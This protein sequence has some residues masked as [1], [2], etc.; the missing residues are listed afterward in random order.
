MSGHDDKN[1]Q[2][3]AAP[4]RGDDRRGD[5]ISDN[6]RRVYREVVDEPLPDAFE[7]LLLKLKK[8]E[9]GASPP[10]ETQQTGTQQTGTEQAAV[11]QQAATRR[12]AAQQPSAA[13]IQAQAQ[14]SQEER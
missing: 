11:Q 12:S 7:A 13:Q 8:S 3:A 1:G 5:M 4:S 10:Q 9:Q 6:L 14:Q 2:K